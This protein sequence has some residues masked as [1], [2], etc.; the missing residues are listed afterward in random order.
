MT[1]KQQQYRQQKDTLFLA[2]YSLKDKK[3]KNHL[4]ATFILVMTF[5]IFQSHV[6]KHNMLLGSTCTHFWEFS[7]VEM[8]VGNRLAGHEKRDQESLHSVTRRTE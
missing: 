2:M 1:E 4:F 3:V 6:A 8:S 5:Y 7:P